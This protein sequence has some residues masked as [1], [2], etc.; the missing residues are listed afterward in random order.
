MTERVCI[1]YGAEEGVFGV[2]LTFLADSLL[3]G[4]SETNNQ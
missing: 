2:W 1:Q 3:E 4:R